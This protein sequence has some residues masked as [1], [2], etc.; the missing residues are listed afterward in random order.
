[1][2]QYGINITMVANMES[3]LTKLKKESMAEANPFGLGEADKQIKAISET[4]SIIGAG[5][6]FDKE[7]VAHITF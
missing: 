4:L 2:A 5:F 6:Y 1:M 3:K 7:M